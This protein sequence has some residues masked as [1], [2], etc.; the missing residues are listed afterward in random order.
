ME[1][2]TK[3]HADQVYL[4]ARAVRTT[5]VPTDTVD[6]PSALRTIVLIALVPL[7]IVVLG[8]LYSTVGL[9]DIDYSLVLFFY[10]FV[11]GVL[12]IVRKH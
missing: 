5:S 6:T 3:E 7:V 10:I 1:N 2:R 12:I 11:P 4:P 9:E 8:L